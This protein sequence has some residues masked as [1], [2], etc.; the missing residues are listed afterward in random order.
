MTLLMD[1]AVPPSR[2][3]LALTALRRDKPRRW[4]GLTGVRSARRRFGLFRVFFPVVPVH[5]RPNTFGDEQLRRIGRPAD[6]RFDIHAFRGVEF[7][8]HVIREVSP[9]ITAPDSHPHPCKFLCPE[10][11]DD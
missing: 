9:G 4:S 6:R 1:L 11:P 7:R 5:H 2:L 8:E 3:P 10:R